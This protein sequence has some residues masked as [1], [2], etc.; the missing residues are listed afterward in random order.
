MAL[1][2]KSKFN[3]DFTSYRKTLITQG[4]EVKIRMEMV[5]WPPRHP[6][7]PPA[8]ASVTWEEGQGR[9]NKAG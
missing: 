3:R 9:E 2:R 4:S 8:P 5:Q 1:I 7:P 6:P